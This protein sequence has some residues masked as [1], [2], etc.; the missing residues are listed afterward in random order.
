MKTATQPRTLKVLPDEVFERAA[1]CLRV[2]A[3]P[4]RLKMV[5][6][7]MQGQFAVHELAELC[8]TTPNQTCEHLR[9]LK[10]HGLL[11]SHRKGRTVYYGIA[12]PQ[13]PRLIE[14]LRKTC[15]E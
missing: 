9:L 5:E 1:E 12:S 15:Q 2:M 11:S 3:H 4:V 8:R 6:L 13:L 7:M 14:C 10:G